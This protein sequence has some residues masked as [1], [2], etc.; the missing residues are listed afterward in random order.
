ME[1]WCGVLKAVSA[2]GTESEVEEAC[3]LMVASVGLQPTLD[4]L[5]GAGCSP[6]A[7]FYR[8]CLRAERVAA[9]KAAVAHEMLGELESHL[10][11]QRSAALGPRWRL[12]VQREMAGLP[13]PE[14]QGDEPDLPL[15]DPLLHWGASVAV[16]SGR[17]PATGVPLAGP[18][19]AAG[20][21]L[22]VHPCCGAAVYGPGGCSACR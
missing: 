1:V 4:A 18:G 12:A 21:A 3:R 8:R 20:R 14:P 10:W 6:G 17:C 9:T 22:S 16:A 5:A 11:T 19:A 15:E 7:A 2:R 13:L